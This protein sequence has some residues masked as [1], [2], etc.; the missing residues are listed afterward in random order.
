VGKGALSR[1]A[2][3]LIP[4]LFALAKMVGTLRFC[5]PYELE[6]KD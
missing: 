2:H 5:P 3:Q 6:L 1:R 4:S